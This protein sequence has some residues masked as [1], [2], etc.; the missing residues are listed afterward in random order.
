MEQKQGVS[1]AVGRMNRISSKNRR[2]SLLVAGSD[3][4][5]SC[6]YS[7]GDQPMLLESPQK[8]FEVHGKIKFDRD[9]RPAMIQSVTR[10]CPVDTGDIP[11]SDVLPDHLELRDPQGPLFSVDYDEEG[12]C[13]TAI[14]GETDSYVIADTR[15]DLMELL[16]FHLFLKWRDV[17]MVGD[18]NLA[19]DMIEVKSALKRIFR[20]K[21]TRPPSRTR[22]PRET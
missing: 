18:E 2:L 6:A 17:A 7:E 19:S 13:Y 15:Q 5:V 22:R 12:Q 16:K 20:E 21:S 14:L 8:L 3:D 9:G 4:V 11:V 10:I 1:V